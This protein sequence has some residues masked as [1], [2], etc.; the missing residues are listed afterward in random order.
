MDCSIITNTCTGFVLY[1]L[2]YHGGNLNFTD[3]G[4]PL[5]STAIPDDEKFVKFA[6]NY[7]YYTGL[8]PVFGM[9]N[10]DSAWRRDS[11]RHYFGDFPDGDPCPVMILDDVEIHWM[12][13]VLGSEQ[14]ILKKWYGGLERGRG[15]PRVFIL[16]VSELFNIHSDEERKQLIDRWMRLDGVSIFITNNAN[17]AYRNS[18]HIC[19]YFAT[20]DGHTQ[21]DR[22]SV[23]FPRWNDRN[24]IA[25]ICRNLLIPILGG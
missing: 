7:D 18:N 16:S 21:H 22:T 6:E 1:N 11:G 10:S 13:E 24:C 9:P 8:T 3:Y 14:L 20:W 17:E 23:F 4:N 19:Y 5:I 2:L 15:L 12:H 25:A